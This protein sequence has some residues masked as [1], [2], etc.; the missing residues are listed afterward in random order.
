MK[1]RHSIVRS[2]KSC[3]CRHKWLFWL[4]AW[5]EESQVTGNISKDIS[6]P[7]PAFNSE[8]CHLILPSGLNINVNLLLQRVFVNDMQ[9]TPRFTGRAT[10]VP[11]KQGRVSAQI[12][13][14]IRV[15]HKQFRPFAHCS[16]S[17]K[18]LR[19]HVCSQTNSLRPKHATFKKNRP[20]HGNT[21]D[22]FLW[23]HR[24]R[25]RVECTSDASLPF[26]P[27]FRAAS[28]Q[29]GV[30]MMQCDHFPKGYRSLFVF[31]LLL[32]ERGGGEKWS[33]KK[34][35]GKLMTTRCFSPLLGN[36]SPCKSKWVGGDLCTVLMRW[37]V[38]GFFAGCV[39]TTGYER[40]WMCVV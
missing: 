34:K 25:W 1:A 27:Y 24:V 30:C 7:V 14:R 15:A 3:P 9:H 12:L 26:T 23:W 35:R 29:E 5:G 37:M 13:I 18:V 40:E 20:P 17:P 6:V 22:L 33:L 38:R 19:E 11:N 31:S 32:M 8:L 36:V 39:L 10:T 2:D 21:V 16:H 28:R 4:G